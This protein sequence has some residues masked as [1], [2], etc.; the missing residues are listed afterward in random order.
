MVGSHIAPWVWDRCMDDFYVDEWFVSD[1]SGGL[2]MSYNGVAEDLACIN[3]KR[4]C[5]RI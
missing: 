2:S 4:G 1:S 5:G 3:V